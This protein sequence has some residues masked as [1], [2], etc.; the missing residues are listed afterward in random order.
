MRYGFKGIVIAGA[1]ALG[2]CGFKPMHAPNALGANTAYRFSDISVTTRENLKKDFLIKQALRDRIGNN[3]GAK[4]RLD[5]ESTVGRKILGVG[6]DDVASRYDLVMRTKFSLI[7]KK[8]GKPVYNGTT[9][10][11]S[12]YGAPRDPYGTISAGENATAQVA[13]ETADRIINR[14]A[15]YFQKTARRQS[16]Q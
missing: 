6:A 7:D 1:L 11:T 12:T 13:A 5:I 16:A 3:A 14:I 15:G 4:Y 9:S 10:A 8:T 2:A